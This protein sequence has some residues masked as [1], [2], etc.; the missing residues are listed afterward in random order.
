MD[1]ILRIFLVL[2]IFH[3]CHGERKID[4]EGGETSYFDWNVSNNNCACK[5]L[6][7][8]YLFFQ[9]QDYELGKHFIDKDEF[10]GIRL[11]FRRERELI[12]GE[13]AAAIILLAANQH[14]VELENRPEVTTR[15]E[16]KGKKRVTVPTGIK[17]KTGLIG[18]RTIYPTIKIRNK[19]GLLRDV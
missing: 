8:I 13:R 6:N 1:L 10:E 2:C 16:R 11:V 5:S 3:T 12:E 15:T 7:K 19:N 14:G 17:F 18:A 9:S 4:W